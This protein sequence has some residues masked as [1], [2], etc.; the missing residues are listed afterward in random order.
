M[1]RYED[2]LMEDRT[3]EVEKK[4]KLLQKEKIQREKDAYVSPEKS[5]EARAEVPR[6]RGCA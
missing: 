4:L 1:H 3:Q 5:E 6:D 2:S